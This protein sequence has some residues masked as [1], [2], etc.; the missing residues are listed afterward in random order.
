MTAETIVLGVAIA[1]LAATN[2][3][4]TGFG[5]ALVM[6][7]LLT[8]AWSVKPAVVTSV[9]LSTIAIVPL[10]AEVRGQVSLP[11]VSVL[12]AG[13]LAGVPPG[14]LL[15]DRLEAE[16]LQVIVAAAVIV[17]VILLYV[18]PSVAGRGDTNLGRLA[19]G[20]ASGSLGASTSLGA[21][22]IVLYL[23]GREREVGAFRAT[24]LAFFV[25]GNLV[26]IAA[27]GAV[28]QASMDVAVMAAAALPAVGLGLIAGGWL[29]RRLAPERF[30][31]VVLA[32]LVA[33]SLAVLA[34][35]VGALG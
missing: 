10:L 17:A 33:T 13:A 9:I 28:G 23:L 7:P 14:V 34:G 12:F 30:R 29:R 19:A 20:F 1:F 6:T 22:P 4:V 32:V 25:P 24:V 26:T 35:G 8:L 27:F 16:A 5:F 2:M 31:A 15:L 18:S 21:P 3:S 11:R